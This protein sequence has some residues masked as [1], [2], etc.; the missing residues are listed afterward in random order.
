MH[1]LGTAI[2]VALAATSLAACGEPAGESASEGPIPI[3]VIAPL[4]GPQPDRGKVLQTAAELAI[5]DVNKDGGV[6]GRDL[7]MV[8]L[9]DANNTNQ[10]VSAAQRLIRNE[11]V[12]AITGI[13]S[14]SSQQ[15]IQPLAEK[16]ST[17][18]MGM[19]A[20]ATGLTDGFKFAFRATGSNDSIGPQIVEFAASKGAKKI[21]V[22]HDDS[23]Y[24]QGMTDE[25]LKAIEEQG[26][27]LAA[28]EVYKTG[29]ADVS[30]QVSKLERSGADSVLAFP[31]TGADIALLTRTMTEN[32][33][34]LPIYSHNG[35]FTKEAISLAGKYFAKLPAVYGGGSVDLSRPETKEFYDRMTEAAGFEVPQNEDAAQTYDAIR[36]VAEG[37]K[38]SGGKGGEELA[39]ALEGIDRYEGMA[40]AK[41]AYYSFGPDK[42]TGLT[43]DYLTIYGFEKD[44]FV[45]AK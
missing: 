27:E 42:H 31:L 43:G 24:A 35:V 21:A 39:A 44:R 25:A 38:T 1:H 4:S 16:S 45:V 18:V 3:G 15:A 28:N 40:G 37:L 5:D 32:G 26:L 13:I 17:V 34:D 10:A 2:C 14:S 22:I 20:T 7:K 8:V 30:A 11:R 29:A 6:D 12:A 23:T 19:I 9:D 36:L 41:D 33:V